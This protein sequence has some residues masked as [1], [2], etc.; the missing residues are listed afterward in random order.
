MADAEKKK[1]GIWSRRDFFTRLGWG[2]VWI[3][4]GL[5]LLGFLRSAFPRVLF[6]PPATFKAGLP[7]GLCRS[8]KSAKS[9][10]Q[11][12]RVWIMRERQRGSMRSSPNARTSAA[13]RAG[14]PPKKNSNAPV[15]AAATI[16]AGLISKA[17]RRDR[18]TGLKSMSAR[19]ANWWS[20]KAKFFKMQPGVE[21][22]EQ[23]SDSILKV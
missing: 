18:W 5:G 14:S 13:R 9:I 3:F 11:E 23:F 15:T 22:D 6:Q 19:T 1:S 12:Q 21:P 2:G 16:K 4:G 17:R 8:A 10:K 20:T 7:G